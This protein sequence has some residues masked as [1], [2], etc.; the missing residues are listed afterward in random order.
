[1]T[2]QPVAAA[3]PA[4]EAPFLPFARP[5]IGEPE[6]A[7]VVECLR[8]GWLTTGPNAKEFET[9][10]A[11]AVHPG[12][13]ALAVNSATSGLHLALEAVGVS[14]GDEVV[15]P[16]YTFTASAE[17]VRY[18]GADP[19]FVDIDP[20]TFNTTA[21]LLESAITERTRAAMPIGHAVTRELIGHITF[22]GLDHF[23][24]AVQEH[25]H[26]QIE[27]QPS[28]EHFTRP[29]ETFELERGLA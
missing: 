3:A 13:R 6:I 15:V 19:A 21:A 23:V 10:F 29:F 12:A 26:G 28:L 16:V 4:P 25:G 20:A 5:D 1:M 27:P 24:Q 22:V 17:V 18:L 11:A 9:R 14:A 7:A 2:A 8:S